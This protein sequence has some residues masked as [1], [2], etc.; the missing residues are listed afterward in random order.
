[1]GGKVVPTKGW[2]EEQLDGKWIRVTMGEKITRS[3]HYA[4]APARKKLLGPL[5][6]AVSALGRIKPIL[7]QF[8][9]KR[10][11]GHKEGV[12]V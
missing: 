7:Q 11:K 5:V 9:K 4:P 8:K 10:K 6:E 3:I 12:D 1:M 2:V